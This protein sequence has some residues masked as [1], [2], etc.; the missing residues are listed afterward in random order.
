M[1]NIED[2]A[3]NPVTEWKT[4][5]VARH[6]IV[7]FKPSFISQ[8]TQAIAEAQSGRFYG[9]TATQCHHLIADLTKAL[10]QLETSVFEVP[11]N[12]KH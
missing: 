12:Q 6:G 9:L 1:P 5:I 8:P 2:T 4:G 3:I 7:V 10:H 11:K